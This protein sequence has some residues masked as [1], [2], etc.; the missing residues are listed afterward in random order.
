[1][2]AGTRGP[3][4]LDAIKYCKKPW[5]SHFFHTKINFLVP[6]S[7]NLLSLRG[8]LRE[9]A[10]ALSVSVGEDGST[11]S[12]AP[13]PGPPKAATH[14]DRKLDWERGGKVLWFSFYSPDPWLLILLFPVCQPQDHQ[15][16][17]FLL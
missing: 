16:L 15:T 2:E 13:A 5:I 1:M 9:H 6:F 11:G 8:S 17:H 14:Q 10:F 4:K 12:P 3:L 7:H